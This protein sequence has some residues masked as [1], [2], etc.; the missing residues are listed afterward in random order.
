MPYKITN[1]VLDYDVHENYDI[2]RVLS[3]LIKNRVPYLQ[4]RFFSRITLEYLFNLINVFSGSVV[5]GL[6]IILP[7]SKGFEENI[8]LIEK[9]CRKNLRINQIIFYHAHFYK[10]IELCDGLTKIVFTTEVFDSEDCC[11]NVYPE[12]FQ[13][14]S[15]MFFESQN[16]NSCLN[17]KLGI[18]RK[19]FLKNCPSMNKSFGYIHDVDFNMISDSFEFKEKW[20]V[21]KDDI[22]VCKDCEF[23]YMCVDC[24]AYTNKNGNIAKPEKCKYNPYLCLWENI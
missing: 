22:E 19:G 16:F 2:Q 14:N 3:M 4:M 7:F 11:G 18:D 17:R 13:I 23:R 8:E 6:D 24:R 15:S 1:A 20:F 10:R 9:N 21:K 12:L 5:K